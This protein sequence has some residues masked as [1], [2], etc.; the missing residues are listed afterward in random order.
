LLLE[1]IFVQLDET[2][3]TITSFK[4]SRSLRWGIGTSLAILWFALQCSTVVLGAFVMAVPV[5]V[6]RWSIKGT[7]LIFLPLA[8][9]VWEAPRAGPKQI[10]ESFGV[11]VLLAGCAPILYLV[12]GVFVERLFGTSFGL[13]SPFDAIV[14]EA[15]KN[16][17]TAAF[18][19]KDVFP[20]WQLLAAVG[21]AIIVSGYA[22]AVRLRNRDTY[23]P[24]Q[25]LVLNLGYFLLGTTVVVL[26][27]SL[28]Y[29]AAT[30]ALKTLL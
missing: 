5:C 16:T 30:T 24:Q 4:S 6:F 25:K 1:V 23:S 2:R 21:A 7:S 10:A 26:I 3:E 13:L 29:V 22:Y 9:L 19:P 14:A 15:A 8:L 12:V 20:A 27:L 18:F 28:V 11:K 17:T